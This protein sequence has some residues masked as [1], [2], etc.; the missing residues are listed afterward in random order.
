MIKDFN[1]HT[2]YK[3]LFIGLLMA[4]LFSS[5]SM[6]WHLMPPIGIILFFVVLFYNPLS[7]TL[8]QIHH[9]KWVIFIFSA[10]FI[11]GL[12]GMS[13]TE[14]KI[15]GWLDVILKSSFLLFAL[16]YAIVPKDFIS[17]NDTKKIL[18]A[19]VLI[20]F[21]SS[22]YCFINAV[23]VYGSSYDSSVFYYTNLSFFQ[24]PSYT[25]LSVNLALLIILNR[26][27][28]QKKEQK[29]AKLLFLLMVPWLIIFLFL[30]QSK[31]AIISFLLLVIL[32]FIYQILMLKQTKKALHFLTIILVI[33]AFSSL[34]VPNSL[35][36]FQ[37]VQ[38]AVKQENQH[39]SEKESTA[40]R[41]TLWGVAIETIREGSVW[42]TG[43]GDVEKVFNERLLSKGFIETGDMAYNSHSQYLQTTMKLGVLGLIA[44][45][46]LLVFPL[47]MGFKSRNLLYLGLVLLMSFNLLVESMF[48]RQAGLMFYAFFNAFIYFLIVR[49]EP[50]PITE[51]K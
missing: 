18:N 32:I 22:I 49:N 38:K 15:D 31:A 27:I 43:T 5:M 1:R 35:D 25:G 21:A 39:S 8:K 41:M 42:G 24:H 12:I 28:Q 36:R 33:T 19:Y 30:L 47:W 34:V 40:A 2:I 13:Y 26:W 10:L 11:A 17:S 48:E 6:W 20:V 44:L 46:G 9:H 4:Y 7:I 3:N 37:R 14:N 50:R 16:T 45:M 51:S 23:I 29:K